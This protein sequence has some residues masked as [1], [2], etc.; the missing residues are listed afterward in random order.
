MEGILLLTNKSSM[1]DVGFSF[2]EN[3]RLSISSADSSNSSVMSDSACNV[4]KVSSRFTENT[5]HSEDK[6]T[7]QTC[8]VKIESLLMVMKVFNLNYIHAYQTW[9]QANEY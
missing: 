1:T 9:F 3:I 8:F 4:Y 7:F 5:S 6:S 2:V